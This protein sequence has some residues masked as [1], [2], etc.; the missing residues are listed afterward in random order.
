MNTP[1][2]AYPFSTADGRFIP[3]DIIKA[4]SLA[5]LPVSV[6]P[7]SVVVP[8]DATDVALVYS[9]VDTYIRMNSST[10]PSITEGAFLAGVLYVPANH[11]M[12]VSLEAGTLQA[13]AAGAESGTLRIQQIVKWGA[14]DTRANNTKR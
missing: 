10:A 12:V 6:T 1:R 4:N 11:A 8:A 3:L 5:I 9:T 7:S 14:F 2:G 13:V